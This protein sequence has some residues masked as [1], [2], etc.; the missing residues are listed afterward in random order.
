LPRQWRELNRWIFPTEGNTRGISYLSHT[1]M[2]NSAY[3]GIGSNQGDKYKNCV[4]AIEM[5]CA[6]EQ[7]RLLIQSSFYLTEPW[8]YQEQDTFINS[9]IKIH[10][11]F[12]PHQLITFL[13]GV[14]EKLGREH[15]EKWGPRTIDLD[16]LFYNDHTIESPELTIPHPLLHLRGF[17]LLPLREID[18]QLIH[19]VCNQTIAQLCESLHDTTGIITLLEERP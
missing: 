18:P 14:E 19:P 9:V 1:E 5:I 13:H 11:T 16:I 17:V 12:S 4:R 6:C 10:T 2:S 8:G 3:I 15:R 7:N